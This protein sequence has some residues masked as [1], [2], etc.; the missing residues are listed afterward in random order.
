MADRLDHEKTAV[1]RHYCRARIMVISMPNE[2]KKIE[3]PG[4][5]FVELVFR[6]TNSAGFKIHPTKL[7][8]ALR[9]VRSSLKPDMW[10][11]SVIR[12]CANEKS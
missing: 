4:N 5:A 2:E 9:Q 3:E 12:K 11:R 6:N 10:Y 7:A 1:K 8:L